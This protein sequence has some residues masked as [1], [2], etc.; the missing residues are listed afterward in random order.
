MNILNISDYEG[1]TLLGMNGGQPE[2]PDGS[3]IIYAKKKDLLTDKTH[4][5][6]C[7]AD[8][9]NHRE[10]YTVSCMNHNGPSATFIDDTRAVFRDKLDG[11]SAFHIVDTSTGKDL[12]EPIRAKE[13]HRAENGIYPF[14]VSREF[15]SKN[16]SYPQI[17]ECGIYLM[18]MSDYSVRLAVS[19]EEIIDMVKKSGLTP[20]ENT[21]SVSHVQLNP[22]A[23]AV[24]MRLG[25]EDCPTFGALGCVELDSKKTHM[26]PDKPVHQLWYDDKSYIAARQ[27]KIDDRIDMETSYLARFSMDGEEMEILGGIANHND[28]SPDRTMTAG[29]R[30]YPG[31]APDIYLYR[32]GDKKPFYTVKMGD[33]QE[34]VWKRQVH[35]NPT[36]SRDG[37]RLYFNCPVSNTRSVARL[38]EIE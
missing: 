13:S 15:L 24:M 36:F 16:P 17:N 5:C 19:E 7:D 29:D 22:S 23:T 4:I 10:I 12:I 25:V 33:F 30:C 3:Q 20:K 37:K 26:I 38:L 28:I 34:A 31:Y 8:L 2:S 9:K 32:K 1:T 11:V 14:S 27:F 35:P 18:D 21:G 6:V